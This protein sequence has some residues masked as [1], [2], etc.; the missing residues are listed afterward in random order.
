M[1]EKLKIGIVGC[2]GIANGKHFPSL[3]KLDQVELVAFCDIEIDRAQK[4]AEQYGTKGAKV[5]EDYRD[6]LKDESID[7]VHVLTPNISHAE[8]SIAA[9]EA[10]KHVMCEMTMAKTMKAAKEMVALANRTR[11]K[12]Y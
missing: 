11:K 6:L 1:S 4:G 5:Y 12:L 9:M 7:V 10:G 3:S 2:G 8:I